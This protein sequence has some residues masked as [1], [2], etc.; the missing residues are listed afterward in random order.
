[1]WEC[2]FIRIKSTW[3]EQTQNGQKERHGK[4]GEGVY[5]VRGWLDLCG[6]KEGLHLGNAEI[7]YA[8]APKCMND[9]E[10]IDGQ[11]FQNGAGV[12]KQKGKDILCQS[13]S[14][15]LLHLRPC[16]GDIRSCETG[17]VDEVEIHI[18]YAQLYERCQSASHHARS[19]HPWAWTVKRVRMNMRHTFFKLFWMLVSISSP[20]LPEYFVVM[21]TSERESPD[22][23]KALPASSSLA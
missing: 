17:A 15:Q 8:D 4:R 3:E 14:L 12:P 1:M 6:G 13:I 7:A 18:G 19:D 2:Q 23:W 20:P 9:V 5:L 22:W 16:C 21:K 11:H 10:W